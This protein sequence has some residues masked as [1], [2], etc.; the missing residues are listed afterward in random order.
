MRMKRVKT[1]IVLLLFHLVTFA[2]TNTISGKITLSDNSPLPNVLV[3]LTGLTPQNATTDSNGNYSFTVTTGGT[4]NVVPTKDG[5]SFNPAYS[6]ITNI[7]SNQTKN[8][9]ASIN[10]LTVS[11]S[12]FCADSAM[13][14]LPLIVV[15]ESMSADTVFTD[16]TGNF[17][18]TKA[19]DA[20]FRLSPYKQGYNFVPNFYDIQQLK[21][22]T[23]L[24]FT[25]SQ[26]TKIISG[27]AVYKNGTGQSGVSILFIGSVADTVSVTTNSNG[28]Y[29]FTGLYGAQY[30]IVPVKDGLN[31][32]P[33]TDKTLF[34]ANDTIVNFEIELNVPEQLSYS[35]D[36]KNVYFKS[37][38]LNWD[39]PLTG[40]LTFD[41]E[42]R[43]GEE[44]VLH[45]YKRNI[46]TDYENIVSLNKDTRYF[47]RVRA[48]NGNDS[49]RWSNYRSF[50]TTN[51]DD[52]LTL[53]EVDYS[54]RLGER[55]PI[56]LIHGLNFDGKPA[57]PSTYHWDSFIN[58]F[59][60]DSTLHSSFKLYKVAYFSN[61][62]SVEEIAADL[63]AKFEI[64]E[65]RNMRF[66]LMGY[67]MGGLIARSFVNRNF[68]TG[69]NT[70][71]A[72]GSNLIRLITFGTPHH[73]SPLANGPARDARLGGTYNPIMKELEKAMFPASKY[74]EANRTDLHW[75][76]YDQLLDYAT[77]SDEAND[78]LNSLN[79]SSNYDTK[80]VVYAGKTQGELSQHMDTDKEKLNV[81]AYI[82]GN[83]LGKQ[84]DGI[85]PYESAIFTNHTPKYIRTFEDY[86]H[87]DIVNGKQDGLWINQ[88]KQ[89][90][91]EVSGLKIIYPSD[92]NITLKSNS[93][94][95]VKW[96]AP[97]F[98]N[99]VDILFS[100]DSTHTFST[101]A[102]N[103]T[104]S[105]KNY[106]IMLPD[107]NTHK[108]RIIVVE[109][110]SGYSS[111]NFTKGTFSISEYPFTVY[112]ERI[113]FIS[114]QTD[115]VAIRSKSM[116]I[117]WL[118]E[119]IG[120]NVKITCSDL[121]TNNNL[122]IVENIENQ[123][124]LNSYTWTIPSDLAVTDSAQIIIQLTDLEQRFADTTKYIFTSNNFTIQ[125][126]PTITIESF[127]Q[128]VQD[129]FGVAG[130]KLE[131]D[132]VYALRW[133][134]K[135]IIRNM[136]I[137]LCDSNKNVIQPIVAREQTPDFEN[138]NSFEWTIPEIPNEK[139]YLKISGG[140]SLDSVSYT[141]FS[142][143]SF[144]INRTPI[145]EFPVNNDSTVSLYP[146]VRF[147]PMT[148][149]SAFH[150][151]IVN[152]ALN[153]N[154]TFT[155]DSLEACLPK[156]IENELTSDTNYKLIVWADWDNKHSYK[157]KQNFRT[158]KVPPSSF[159]IFVPQQA[160]LTSSDSLYIAWNNSI[161][162]RK[163]DV[164]LLKNG[165]VF[166]HK[167]NIEKTD[168]TVLYVFDRETTTNDT[169]YINV[170]AIHNNDT[171]ISST[172]YIKT[173]VFQLV[174]FYKIHSNNWQRKSTN[175]L[176]TT[177]AYR[178]YLKNE[179]AEGGHYQ[180]IFVG[181]GYIAIDLAADSII[182]ARG[183]FHFKESIDTYLPVFDGSVRFD[184]IRLYP[185]NH[186]A[187]VESNLVPSLNKEF[188]KILQ[189]DLKQNKIAIGYTS[190]FAP[191]Y[192]GVNGGDSKPLQFSIYQFTIDN[193]KHI[194]GDVHDF[195]VSV[196]PVK[197]T[198]KQVKLTETA[199][200]DLCVVSEK[201]D[202]VLADNDFFKFGIT[203]GY[204]A[205]FGIKLKGDSIG[206]IAKDVNNY[207]IWGNSASI[208]PDLGFM[209]TRL[210]A[211]FA[212]FKYFS[213]EQKWG[214]H[215]EAALLFPWALKPQKSFK[216]AFSTA[217][218]IPYIEAKFSMLNASPYI[219][220]ID[221]KAVN[222]SAM[223][224]GF[225]IGLESVWELDGLSA[226]YNIA[227]T[228][229]EKFKNLTLNG[230]A[231]ILFGP[232]IFDFKVLSFK[233]EVDFYMQK[234]PDLRE[235]FSFIGTMKLLRYIS[236]AKAEV[237]LS[238]KQSDT[239]V[240]ILLN[241]SAELAFPS[242]TNKLISG[243]V[244][245]NMLNYYHIEGNNVKPGFDFGVSGTLDIKLKKG[246]VNY[247]GIDWPENEISLKQQALI[248]KIK[249][250]N[251]NSEYGFAFNYTRDIRYPVSVNC[252]TT[253]DFPYISCDTE[254]R[255]KALH[256]GYFQPL[257][258]NPVCGF[259]N[260]ELA[261]F[262][263]NKTRALHASRSGLK[264][265]KNFTQRAERDSFTIT[266]PE[267]SNDFIDF[268]V[269]YS[270][271]V[272]PIV[273]LKN[274]ANG[275]YLST[276]YMEHNPESE[277]TNGFVMTLE[278]R[279]G[280]WI[281][282]IPNSGEVEDYSVKASI[283]PK[284]DTFSFDNVTINSENKLELNCSIS[285]TANDSANVVFYIAK[286]DSVQGIRLNK[287]PL[288]FVNGLLEQ[289]F[290]IESFEA[291][292]YKLY[293]I[294][295]DGI[296]IPQ[297]IEYN[298]EI[299]FAYN[300]GINAP[301]SFE[302]VKLNDET[303]VKWNA[304][305]GSKTYVVH[306]G[307][308]TGEYSQEF[309]TNE[310]KFS[311]G[312]NQDSTFFVVK[313]KSNAGLLSEAS[314]E[315]LIVSDDLQIDTIAPAVPQS[316]QVELHLTGE[317]SGRYAQF[318]WSVSD[319][320]AKGFQLFVKNNEEESCYATDVKTLTNIKYHA[321]TPGKSYKAWVQAYDAAGN[322]SDKS[323]EL[324]F[325]FFSTDDTDVDGMNDALEKMYFNSIDVIND[326][327]GDKD[328][329]GIQN[330]VE[331]NQGTN[332]N[333]TDT[334]DDG[335]DDNIDDHPLSDADNDNDG[336]PDDWENYFGIS[337][338]LDD[339]DTDGLLNKDEY[340]HRSNPT[341]ADTDGGGL[342]DGDEVD[343][344]LNPVLKNDDVE[345]TGR[346]I[347]RI[348]ETTSNHRGD[349]VLISWKTIDEDLLKGFD[350]YRR[351]N[352][353]EN[354]KKI[355]DSLIVRVNV[356]S[357]TGE[358]VFNDNEI[359]SKQDVY[360]LIEGISIGVK[361]QE[362]AQFAAIYEDFTLIPDLKNEGNKEK[363]FY[364]FP[365]P[366]VDELTIQL[367]M[368]KI[369]Q[370][371][372]VRISDVLGKEIYNTHFSKNACESKNIHIN[373]EALPAGIY[374][375]SVNMNGEN[376]TQ[377]AIIK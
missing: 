66:V 365:N 155:I 34:L 172:F 185:Q 28:D 292:D 123:N 355:N 331:M 27:R 181:S 361:K 250:S 253:W 162:A 38:Y 53:Q 93:T 334:D 276:H 303:T 261:T 95:Q 157:I 82:L 301:E 135:G 49:S 322:I 45:T 142:V 154:K 46:S 332:P 133:K 83:G 202:L 120:E 110:G 342:T 263:R 99:Q 318:S 198:C 17:T 169:I 350:L 158:A 109:S 213:D 159:N 124:G 295:E 325:D 182:E 1:S 31:F 320:D 183:K 64:S 179:Y 143:N 111:D 227:T 144:R 222:L 7:V 363:P 58:S 85:V 290:D 177:G 226:M 285:N 370:D 188:M 149:A 344:G 308:K 19:Y 76:N 359:L 77:Y 239:Y 71:Q 275:A 55:L 175:I 348:S 165:V 306:V 267:N 364:V 328:G 97:A 5:Y 268:T 251:S 91:S 164:E 15:N 3:Q 212:D 274:P 357:T 349:S 36:A 219:K 145:V 262:N 210:V 86:D 20:T 371:I 47:W 117:K 32:N 312:N 98:I 232:S 203:A 189:W 225:G 190:S 340:L 178:I 235:D 108:A 341:I 314:T 114:P 248:G 255:Y 186:T 150:I 106:N 343:Y 214:L 313:G 369:N 244:N 310:S 65:I 265:I 330:I 238:S 259:T 260:Y 116:E 141:E 215:M 280:D 372:N 187:L 196:G 103:V 101:L 288:K 307:N 270:G 300:G 326:K 105:L 21:K 231:S 223:T 220:L 128:Q 216:G 287:T 247:M 147:K 304:S 266:I 39:H 74:N 240:D 102:S 127:A 284:E 6:Q 130:E 59:N 26:I 324:N 286:N 245:F 23:T 51:Q 321:L 37:L 112:R 78:W 236:L 358:Y 29:S 118:H 33:Q 205:D 373:M 50:K 345:G 119:G 353:N 316:L 218:S 18:F 62:K 88:V 336:M 167:A 299:N 139:L 346:I 252:H 194:Q 180:D 61:L 237:M 195:D 329:D 360:Y 296:N 356:N 138:N 351:F 171:T 161:G 156:T 230:S 281:V 327:N 229:D 282:M 12:A 246:L 347:A 92:N 84:S 151:N 87:V 242:L 56:I 305:K 10:Q 323:N 81:G 298:S 269:S 249:T 89:D 174:D 75:T 257:L 70:G 94:I 131:I 264:N 148:K 197:F 217:K 376:F 90:L 207:P 234:I 333:N 72:I 16:N 173:S 126:L 256:I 375:V 152:T 132:S 44:H 273:I 4:Y 311:V 24:T 137:S 204:G 258:G 254:W 146:C 377:K 289:T 30:I 73:G 233:G 279:A 43:Q 54:I 271:T 337:S 170:K 278:N 315:Q 48:V 221:V 166:W 13:K 309:E 121:K 241:G 153:Y 52:D 22:D 11:G 352:E 160:S 243:N 339:S 209:N 367:T 122:L 374:F 100:T 192:P 14:Q 302:F 176:E 317:I 96:N 184:S 140:P 41:L 63:Q 42:L 60:A 338:P 25:A 113:N 293:A 80:T 294:F 35:D 272:R 201:A 319:I 8:F 297:K 366:F 163:Y 134:T 104:A 9:S 224:V 129:D 228:P 68:T 69:V 206:F 208:F 115:S 67:S 291:I 200:D 193:F 283:T 107:T 79:L 168:T 199:K 2:S 40:E 136:Q 191:N 277:G 57:S 125:Y 335:I 362:L 354:W 211:P 368:G